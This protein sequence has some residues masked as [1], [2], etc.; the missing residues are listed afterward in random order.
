MLKDLCTEIIFK[1][2]LKNNF[3]IDE[4]EILDHYKE[5]LKDSFIKHNNNLKFKL[6]NVVKN[7]LHTELFYKN[8]RIKNICFYTD[9]DIEI[10][11]YKKDQSE[12]YY[13]LELKYFLRNTINIKSDFYYKIRL[14]KKEFC[15]LKFQNNIV[16]SIINLKGN[17]KLKCLYKNFIYIHQLIKKKYKD[18]HVT[19][20]DLL[21]KSSIDLNSNFEKKNIDFKKIKSIELIFSLKPITGSIYEYGYFCINSI[22]FY[23]TLLKQTEIYD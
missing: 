11:L 12:I 17:H 22:I 18:L 7:K 5:I 16:K 6:I 2:S 19:T 13:S 14:K 1:E 8:E 10:D 20:Y 3:L 9:C 15:H 4:L 23:F 21:D